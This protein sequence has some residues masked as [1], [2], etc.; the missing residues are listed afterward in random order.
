VQTDLQHPLFNP[1]HAPLKVHLRIMMICIIIAPATPAFM[2]SH[3][4]LPLL[5]AWGESC[6]VPFIS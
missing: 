4:L 2:L 1:L 3:P 6:H 5:H